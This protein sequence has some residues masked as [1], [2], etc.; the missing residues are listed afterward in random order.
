MSEETQTKAEV[1]PQGAAFLTESWSPS[2]IL[3]FGPV[4]RAVSL[5]GPV[6][7]ESVFPLISQI[8][9]LEQRDPGK[10]IR[11]HIN[12]EGGSLA[13]ALALYDALR[14]VTGP[15][16]TVATGMCASAGLLLLSAGD[17]R[18][19]T[20]NTLFFYHEPILPLDEIVSKKQLNELVKAYDLC[21]ESY[22]NIIKTRTGISEEIW[23]EEFE[24]ETSKYFD[25]EKALEYNFID[26][27]ISKAKKA[28]QIVAK[29]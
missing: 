15:I 18:L 7:R 26:D 24:N 2:D 1:P 12:T 5:Y 8:L 14:G 10:P 13:D 22:E 28:M 11:L 4:R 21:K 17:L 19:S 16:I 27:V 9:E 29:E 3:Y 23:S 6:T 25:V 20:E